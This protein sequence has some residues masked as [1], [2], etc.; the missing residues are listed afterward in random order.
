MSPYKEKHKA[1]H[2][3]VYKGSNKE[4]YKLLCKG[5]YMV[6]Y[7]EIY[8]EIYIQSQQYSKQLLQYSMYKGSHD[9]L[10]NICM[11]M[12]CKGNS[13]YM[14][15]NGILGSIC[16]GIRNRKCSIYMGSK[17]ILGNIYREM[18]S[19]LGSIYS[20]SNYKHNNEEE[21]NL[22]CILLLWCIH[23]KDN[24]GSNKTFIY[25]SYK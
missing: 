8:M 19:I 4:I 22:Q 5:I 24:H 14:G 23:Y 16:M 7:K 17:D 6:I 25:F 21:D 11:E 18:C 15:R 10:H 20:Y 12:I 9:I 2:R 1:T 3:L 13:I